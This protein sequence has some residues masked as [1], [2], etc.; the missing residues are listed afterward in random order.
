MIPLVPH[1]ETPLH[2]A[3]HRVRSEMAPKFVKDLAYESVTFKG[4]TFLVDKEDVHLLGS[5]AWQV[6]SVGDR[7]YLHRSTWNP[8]R[9]G[10][11]TIIFHRLILGVDDTAISVDHID[12]N[13]LDCRKANLRLC[14]NGQNR[15]NSRMNTNNSSGFR[16]VSLRRRDGRWIAKISNT[17]IGAFDT[18]EQASEAYAREAER[19]YGEF[20]KKGIGENKP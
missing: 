13:T 9:K 14:S 2:D 5:Y 8:A 19:Q 17:F 12:G 6:K 18:P 15:V 16:G 4:L 1:L 20:V 3:F 7:H 11:S 10:W